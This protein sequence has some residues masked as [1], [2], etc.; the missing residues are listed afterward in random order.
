M[1]SCVVS[2]GIWLHKQLAACARWLV[3]L[4]ARCPV[5]VGRCAW[6]CAS[7]FVNPVAEEGTCT[8]HACIPHTPLQACRCALSYALVLACLFVFS[9]LLLFAS[10]RLLLFSVF[11]W[12]SLCP[13]LVNCRLPPVV[14]RLPPA[15]CRPRSRLP[16]VVCRL[17][18]VVCRVSTAVCRLSFPSA[19]CRMSPSWSPAVCRL[20]SAACR[21]PY[22]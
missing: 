22:S 6:V 12:P 5:R 15:V 17:P 1:V 13:P 10:S 19:A 7:G 4:P 21:L 11:D 8:A 18:P 2:V 14:C 20:P 9:S 16:Y 3:G